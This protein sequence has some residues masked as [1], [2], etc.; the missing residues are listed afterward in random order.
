MYVIMT[1]KTTATKNLDS[2]I[3]VC[4]YVA[5]DSRIPVYHLL[6]RHFVDPNVCVQPVIYMY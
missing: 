6:L 2:Y 5:P 3:Y 1:S 4:T